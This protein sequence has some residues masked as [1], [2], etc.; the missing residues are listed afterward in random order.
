[1]LQYRTGCSV[2]LALFLATPHAVTDSATTAAAAGAGFGLPRQLVER[3][4]APPRQ[5]VT[6][7]S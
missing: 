2:L 4:Q 1:V 3:S 7:L 5:S 6:F